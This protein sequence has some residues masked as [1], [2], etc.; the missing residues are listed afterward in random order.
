[1]GSELRRSELRSTP[2]PPSTAWSAWLARPTRANGWVRPGSAVLT[3]APY[4]VLDFSQLTVAAGRQDHLLRLVRLRLSFAA[5]AQGRLRSVLGPLAGV[6]LEMDL[7]VTRP[8][9]PV[10]PGTR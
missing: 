2:L 4:G 7:S 3:P 9:Q 6:R 5:D 10:S 8:N 1:M